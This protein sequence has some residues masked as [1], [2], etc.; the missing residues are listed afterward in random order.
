MEICFASEKKYSAIQKFYY[1]KK[2]YGVIHNN[3][4]KL[5]YNGKSHGTIPKFMEVLFIME[6]TM[7]LLY[8]KLWY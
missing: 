7:V 6:E 2:H 1:G 4:R 3:Y 8:L 5:V